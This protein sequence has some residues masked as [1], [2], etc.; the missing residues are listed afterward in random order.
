MDNILALP[1]RIINCRCFIDSRSSDSVSCFATGVAGFAVVV[2]F[3]F[4]SDISTS[5]DGSGISSIFI[6]SFC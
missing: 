4:C 5:P 3:I 2:I 6:F 1:P